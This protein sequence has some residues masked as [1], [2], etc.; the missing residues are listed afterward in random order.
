MKDSWLV[1]HE[2]HFLMYLHRFPFV[3]TSLVPTSKR[4][5]W[6]KSISVQIYDLLG[7]KVPKKKKHAT[8]GKVSQHRTGKTGCLS[9]S[10]RERVLQTGSCEWIRLLKGSLTDNCQPYQTQLNTFS[11]L[12]LFTQSPENSHL[13]NSCFS[14][15]LLSSSAGRQN[16][17]KWSARVCWVVSSS[18]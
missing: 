10:F 11:P 1:Q 7:W 18:V 15:A 14:S 6:I 3:L 16:K 4:T 9:C 13:F 2:H 8:H 12:K 17:K 5:I